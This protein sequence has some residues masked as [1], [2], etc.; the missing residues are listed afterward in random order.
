MIFNRHRLEEDLERIRKSGLSPE[1]LQAENEKELALKE[2]FLSEDL[3]FTAKDIF[4]MS[5]AVFT[6]ILPYAV[7]TFG[8][9][10]LVLWLMLR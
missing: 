6:L 8:G 4:A 10:S 2:K 1:E 9:V 3:K 7:I 5:V